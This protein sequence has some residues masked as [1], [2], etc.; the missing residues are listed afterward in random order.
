M[1]LH[2]N[3]R[4]LRNSHGVYDLILERTILKLFGLL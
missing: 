4:D 2:E 1:F 3:L